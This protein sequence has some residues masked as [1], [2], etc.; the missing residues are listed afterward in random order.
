MVGLAFIEIAG[1]RAGPGGHHPALVFNMEPP[2]GVA[3]SFAFNYLS[4]QADIDATVRANGEYAVRVR[5]RNA[6]NT[7]PV[8]GVRVALWGDP[9][10]P[11]H[12]A[13]RCVGLSES[14]IENG[15][16]PRCDTV[17]GGEPG[18]P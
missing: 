12:D 15:I 18:T 9:A 4:A 5:T 3:A 6:V 7:V 11:V 13:Q 1:G 8:L 2:P 10:D 14:P 17:F 16:P